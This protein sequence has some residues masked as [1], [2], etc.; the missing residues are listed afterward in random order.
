M[1]SFVSRFGRS[2]RSLVPPP[3]SL[4]F[5]SC[6]HSHPTT[7][8]H[9]CHWVAPSLSLCRWG[10]RSLRSCLAPW[11]FRLRRSRICVGNR[12]AVIVLPRA[13]KEEFI[14]SRSGYLSFGTRSGVVSNR[15]NRLAFGSAACVHL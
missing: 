9:V 12:F 10:V 8:R 14:V 3:P 6:P 7:L 4:S 1:R 15:H 2:P 11:G 5:P 13:A